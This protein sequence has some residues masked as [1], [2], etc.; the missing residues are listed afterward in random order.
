MLPTAFDV[1]APLFVIHMPLIG[2][3]PA[4]VLIC[5]EVVCDP[6]TGLMP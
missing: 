6:R 4:I 5:W 3:P 1:L 2:W